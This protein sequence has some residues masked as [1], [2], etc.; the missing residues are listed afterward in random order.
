MTAKE[1]GDSREPKMITD[2]V[3]IRLM[4]KKG[5]ALKTIKDYHIQEAKDVEISISTDG[6]FIAILRK[7]LK[8]LQI[9]K[10]EN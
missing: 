8:N 5:H 7:K 6:K 10:I 4:Q 2:D 9:F 3:F 1:F